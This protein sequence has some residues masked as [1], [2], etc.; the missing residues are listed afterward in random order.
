MYIEDVIN[1]WLILQMLETHLGLEILEAGPV[2]QLIWCNK[3][4][5]VHLN[6]LN[7]LW[8]G[9]TNWKWNR[10]ATKSSPPHVAQNYLLQN[11]QLYQILKMI[12]IK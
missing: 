11:Y 1:L 9:S 4:L 10:R 6:H 12:E 5:T 7:G 3:R 2:F 8:C